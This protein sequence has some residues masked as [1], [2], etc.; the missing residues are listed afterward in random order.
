MSPLKQVNDG[1]PAWYAGAG[2]GE[3]R[4][5]D[6]ADTL[7]AMFASSTL[8]RLSTWLAMLA[9]VW[10]ALAP[11]LAQAVVRSAPTPGDGWVEVCS[12]SGMV[13]VSLDTG[14][15]QPAPH[16]G[17]SDGPSCDWCALHGGAPGAPVAHASWPASGVM[18]AFPPAF[19]QAPVTPAVWRSALSRAPP[20]V[21]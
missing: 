21:V 11:T 7:R 5:D 9:V 16:S 14:K 19:Y 17:S 20:T 2:L 1:M 12:V 3:G 4:T 8:K 10:G 15:Q 18:S 13:W 6:A